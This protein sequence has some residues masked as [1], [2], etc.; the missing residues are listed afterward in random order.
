MYVYIY[1]YVYI[2]IYIYIYIYI[3]T[4]SL[5]L[6]LSLS[7]SI[8]IYTYMYYYMILLPASL[9]WG[10]RRAPP[11][12]DFRRASRQPDGLTIHTK[13]GFPGAGFLGAPPISLALLRCGRRT[14]AEGVADRR[15]QLSRIYHKHVWIQHH[16]NHLCQ[17]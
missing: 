17:R 3:C 11:H 15:L 7:L 14:Y 10:P 12:P 2:H 1:I 5:S 8:Y 13:K 6:Y 9:L 16:L 4:Y